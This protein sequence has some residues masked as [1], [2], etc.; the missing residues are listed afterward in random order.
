[1]TDDPKPEEETSPEQEMLKK[2]SAAAAKA[3][4]LDDFDDRLRQ[5][6]EKAAKASGRLQKEKKEESRKMA[7]D[8]EAARGLGVGL[9][10]AYTLI[11]LPMIG[12][13]VGWW[14]DNR[15]HTEIWKSLLILIGSVAA[16]AYTVFTLNQQNSK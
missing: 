9:S 11:G 13:A 16:I 2:V 15:F 3:P 4:E 8:S 14:L 1:M 7:S 10:I 6:E 5:L 12:V